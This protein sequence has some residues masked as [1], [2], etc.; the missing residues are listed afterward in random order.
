MIITI[1]LPYKDAHHSICNYLL[2]LNNHLDN[3]D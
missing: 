3:P 2:L 1:Q